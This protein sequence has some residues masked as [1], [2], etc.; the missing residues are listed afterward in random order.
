[1]F[2]EVLETHK[3]TVDTYLEGIIT[4]SLQEASMVQALDEVG[5]NPSSLHASGRRARHLLD[6]A[7]ERVGGRGWTSPFPDLT[8]DVELGGAWFTEKPSVRRTLSRPSAAIIQISEYAGT[9]AA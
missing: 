7:R 5:G 6:E 3:G 4:G 9:G 8:A 1:M 2:Q